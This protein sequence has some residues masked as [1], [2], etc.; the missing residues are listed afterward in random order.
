MPKKTVDL[1]S[2]MSSRRAWIGR[3]WVVDKENTGRWWRNK[4][5]SPESFPI[6]FSVSK[7]GTKPIYTGILQE[8]LVACAFQVKQLKY[9]LVLDVSSFLLLSCLFA[10][11]L[12][13]VL[14]FDHCL[15]FFLFSFFAFLIL[16][17]KKIVAQHDQP[18]ENLSEWRS[19]IWHLLSLGDILSPFSSTS[20][21]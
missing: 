16:F 14:F 10:W 18:W 11:V 17:S 20:N 3:A 1:H 8:R 15:F 4:Y 21:A 13:F 2:G 9:M 19:F 7:S 6:N 5:L 12:Y